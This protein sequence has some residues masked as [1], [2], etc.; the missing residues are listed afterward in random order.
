[1]SAVADDLAQTIA[2][3]RLALQAANAAARVPDVPVQPRWPD[4]PKTAS[5]EPE[6]V[7][8]RLR[9][10]D[11][12]ERDIERLWQEKQQ[13]ERDIAQTA[14]RHRFQTGRG[15]ADG[16][17]GAGEEGGADVPVR[18]SAPRATRAARPQDRPQSAPHVGGE[19]AGVDHKVFL[20]GLGNSVA[21]EIPTAAYRRNDLPATSPGW[22][23]DADTKFSLNGQ[24][25]RP[26]LRAPPPLTEH[27]DPS[28]VDINSYGSMAPELLRHARGMS[29][30]AGP[31]PQGT[32]AQLSPPKAS[33]N[34][35]LPPAPVPLQRPQ[36]SHCAPD[37]APGNNEWP[38]HLSNMEQA[39][40]GIW[41]L[42]PDDALD[43]RGAEFSDYS[44]YGV[45]GGSA[46]NPVNNSHEAE[47]VYSDYGGTYSL[48]DL[49]IPQHR[50][51]QVQFTKNH[52]A[53][54]ALQDDTRN[55][56]RVSPRESSLPANPK[57]PT[58]LQRPDDKSQ[59]GLPELVTGQRRSLRAASAPSLAA[60]AFNVELL[61]VA[62]PSEQLFADYSQPIHRPTPRATANYSQSI[63]APAR[64][65]NSTLSPA[66][67]ECLFSAVLSD[68]LPVV[69]QTGATFHHGTITVHSH[70]QNRPQHLEQPV[71]IFRTEETDEVSIT[72]SALVRANSD[73]R[74]HL[75]PAVVLG[76]CNAGFCSRMLFAFFLDLTQCRYGCLG[77]GW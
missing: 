56:D 57:A 63:K 8:A 33:N 18:A 43:A 61:P 46:S 28:N 74:E 24:E 51:K 20:S 37:S 38:H 5:S 67:C 40:K 47:V 45:S 50:P 22:E 65:D 66:T 15:D 64:S 48:Q 70:S 31:S 76:L 54:P 10:E 21:R 49:K 39:K 25:N 42:V 11:E 75:R 4:P 9:E 34:W 7:I 2:G 62:P 35:K 16:V 72:I 59:E 17:V 30:S 1:M 32:H 3:I 6:R 26:F 68:D 29:D 13:L 58:L 14:Q 71:G 12:L 77:L 23:E 69:D 73:L 41:Q 36:R 52:L 19:K 44:D 55:R 60:D 27:L 53:L